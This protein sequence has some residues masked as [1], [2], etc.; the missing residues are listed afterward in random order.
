M[1]MLPSDDGR[2]MVH[3]SEPI[4]ALPDGSAKVSSIDVPTAR[5]S[6]RATPLQKIS[7]CLGENIPGTNDNTKENSAGE[8]HRNGHHG[9]FVQGEASAV[10]SPFNST[11]S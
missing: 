6:I 8:T 3:H 1:A 11:H 2:G 10:L 7:E 9:K 5:A 4:L